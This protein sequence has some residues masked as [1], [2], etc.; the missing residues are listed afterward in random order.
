MYFCMTSDP[1]AAK[2]LTLEEELA[3][4][5]KLAQEN[6]A[7]AQETLGFYFFTGADF[8][9][10]KIKQDRDLGI[11]LLKQA[12]EAESTF[13]LVFLASFCSSEGYREYYDL[14][15]A[16]RYTEIL[17]ARGVAT[18][19]YLKG[20]ILKNIRLVY[21]EALH[22]FE[23]AEEKGYT[24]GAYEQ[25][26]M[27]M[28]GIG[29]ERDLV[30]TREIIGRYIEKDPNFYTLQ[31]EFCMTPE[32]R[33]LDQAALYFEKAAQ[34][35]SFSGMA[36]LAEL[37]LFAP[38]I[39]KPANFKKIALDYLDRA[40]AAGEG[41]AC[42]IK[43]R[44]YGKGVGVPKSRDKHFRYLEQGAGYGYIPAELK[45]SFYLSQQDL[46]AMSGS[47][48][49]ELINTVK[50]SVE[51]GVAARC[52]E[53]YT[54]KG[55]FCQKGRIYA[56]DE[57]EAF[58]CYVKA[59]ALGDGQGYTNAAMLCRSGADRKPDLKKM[60]DLLEKAVRLGNLDAC[61]FLGFIKLKS[62]D[63]KEISRALELLK[64][65]GDCGNPDAPLALAD[66]YWK[67]SGAVPSAA[68]LKLAEQYY[69]K[70]IA[71]GNPE[72]H[73]RLAT[74]LFDVN[75]NDEA[76]LKKVSKTILRHMEAAA[77]AEI[78]EACT[79]L[80][81]MY[82]SGY[83]AGKNLKRGFKLAKRSADLGNCEAHKILALCYENGMGTAPS[84]EKAEEEEEIFRE[85]YA[86]LSPD[87]QEELN[88]YFES[89]SAGFFR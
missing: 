70:A 63:E 12:A 24:G 31:G 68:D 3:K 17:M 79:H 47:E 77:D 40:I 56:Q 37:Y 35:G 44:M 45:L 32:Y 84:L 27:Y 58:D 53:A 80:A 38:T 64:Y 57:K 60:C 25:A 2:D 26:F 21:K 36:H 46:N 43:A 66:H 75:E 7:T 14:P 51:R 16:E 19:Y 87:E 48:R 74:M 81:I 76:K 6:D 88:V 11:K 62:E 86:E 89:D 83:G 61:A 73:Y 15:L 78:P 41:M 42:Y 54:L 13:A 30:K 33:D 39:K 52:A 8:Y 1:F 85:M 71:A 69:M 28:N 59:G 29:T 9:G 10:R 82:L 55:V 18:G 65:A 72:G 22:F 5:N 4:L 67:R 20:L 34:A 50:N 23:L 49:E